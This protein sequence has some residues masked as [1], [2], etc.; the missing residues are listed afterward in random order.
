MQSLGPYQIREELGRG[1]A[2]VV[3][4]AHDPRLRRD[5]AIKMLLAVDASPTQLKR[6]DREARA[7]A[8]LRHPNIVA[9]HETS[10]DP[11]GRPY[12][13]MDHVDGVDLA[14]R[15]ADGGPLA[16][17]EAVELARKLALGIA[18]AHDLGIL[19]RD[20][21]PDNVLLT[22]TG[23]PRLTDFGLAKDLASSGSGLIS[24][25]GRFVGTPGFWSPEQ[26]R[27]DHESMGPPTDVYGL[28]ATLFAMLTGR[29]V[30][31]AARMAEAIVA[32]LSRPA[33]PPSSLR[34]GIPGALDEIVLRC[35]EKEPADRYADGRALAEVLARFLR[36][37]EIGRASPARRS[38]TAGAPATAQPLPDRV[39]GEPTTRRSSGSGVS[40]RAAVGLGVGAAA[41][42]AALASA[43][44]TVALTRPH[45]T[46][47]P[48]AAPGEVDRAGYLEEMLARS[49][50]DHAKLERDLEEAEAR[51]RTLLAARSPP[52]NEAARTR[53]PSAAGAR[54][55]EG[56][57]DPTDEPESV[58]S[59]AAEI[60]SDLAD[61]VIALL[62]GDDL[63]GAIATCDAALE[64]DPGNATALRLRGLAK[65]RSGD[66]AGAITD[67]ERAI[68]VDPTSS[69]A[70]SN[71]GSVRQLTGDFARAITE[72]DRA[73][74]LD[75]N[76]WTAYVARGAVK[77]NSG[78]YAGSIVDS[79]IAISREPSCAPAWANRA[80]A[81]T[82]LGDLEGAITDY[83]GLIRLQ[84]SNAEAW[85]NRGML[86]AKRGDLEGAIVD[87]EEAIRLGHPESR[88][89]RVA[90]ARLRGD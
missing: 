31:E 70:W 59:E 72:C 66:L 87:F 85:G 36:G 58:P 55:G 27:G 61:R 54:G 75:P 47:S 62:D 32:A 41:L 15:L 80:L 14:D 53:E 49:S 50:A 2:G 13:V 71:L 28:G 19:H 35:L 64:A 60:E 9:V 65:S 52:P 69:R 88:G 23:E 8:R 20:I 74:A 51:I 84:P 42:G 29:A 63:A 5:V 17:H 57:P 24:I 26:A 77:A 1:G 56:P 81:K 67:L 37:D 25:C 6:F 68:E 43:V 73:L 40:V 86:R 79:D 38:A 3:Y 44:T 7:L 48:V 10:H 4:R 83:G 90:V 34:D 82:N 89:L 11:D 12:I 78:D 22:A 21:K 46:A 39:G 33:K 30:F 76:D 45:P 18:A 16:P